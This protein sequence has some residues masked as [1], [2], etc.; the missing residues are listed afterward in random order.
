[1]TQ[2]DNIA[3]LNG[4][5]FLCQQL[6]TA[7]QDR[8]IPPQLCVMAQAAATQSCGCAPRTDTPTAT[9]TTL[10]PTGLATLTPTV[11]PYPTTSATTNFDQDNNQATCLLCDIGEQVASFNKNTTLEF[12][13]TL[14]T[15]DRLYK[16]AA[17]GR[18][19]SE[20]IIACDDIVDAFDEVCECEEIVTA[21]PTLAPTFEICLVCGPIETIGNRNTP[22]QLFQGTTINSSNYTCGQMYDDAMAGRFDPDSCDSVVEAFAEVCTCLEEGETLGPA[23]A[24]TDSPKPSVENRTAEPTVQPTISPAPTL[25]SAPS[26]APS[27]SS[28]PT[29]SNAP[30]GTNAPSYSE[31]CLVC[32]GDSSNF[33]VFESRKGRELPRHGLYMSTTRTRRGRGFGRARDFL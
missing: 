27:V 13:N 28:A 31:K 19:D 1:M 10:Q 32:G 12:E 21:E 26:A 15:C 29:I 24:P 18:F 4:Q 5:A 22:V 3:K 2:P 7:G 9:P 17:A 8:K 11:T 14:Y 25:S 16:D 23:V 30:T 6:E 20:I 33:A